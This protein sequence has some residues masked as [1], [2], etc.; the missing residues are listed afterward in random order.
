[1]A[2]SER[3]KEAVIQAM[4]NIWQTA[5]EGGMPPVYIDQEGMWVLD[6]R[7]NRYIKLIKVEL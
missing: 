2:L 4:E 7:H 6:V 5:C 3:E 1:M